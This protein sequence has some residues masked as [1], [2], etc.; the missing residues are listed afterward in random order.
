M[1]LLFITPFFHPH[2]GGTELY[3]EGLLSH[4]VS[5]SPQL[6][7]DGLCYNTDKAPEF[8]K[9]KGLDIY[10]VPCLKIIPGQFVVPKLIPLIKT[11]FKLSKNKY[12]HVLT[13]TRIFD[14]CWWVWLYAK[15]VG[16]KS[17]FIGHGAD[18]V[19]HSSS[20][21]EIVARIVDRTLAPFFVRFYSKV[22]VISSATKYFYQERLG[23][24]NLTLIYGGLDTAQFAGKI[25]SARIIPNI[26]R[27]ID[28][29][30]VLVA[31]V[32]RL[33]WAKGV[34]LMYE[35]FKGVTSTKD[36]SVNLVFAGVGDLQKSLE[37]KVS[38]D[39]LQNRVFFTGLLDPEEVR[40]LLAM[41]DIFVNPSFNEGLP[42][43]VLE[44]AAAGCFV[45]A[46][47]VGSTGEIIQDGNTGMLLES[48]SVDSME[49]AL[50]WY[51]DHPE[52]AVKMANSAQVYV[53]KFF[54]W[55]V[56]SREFYLEVLSD[57]VS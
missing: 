7:V 23:I 26:G 11:L 41:T 27:H 10:R 30:E 2:R 18:F 15:L 47:D 54:D 38:K 56:V 3:A 9:Y 39:G 52:E 5:N 25:T 12:S 1:R 36:S 4:L 14:T 16:A 55:S 24:K 13:Q 19:H 46:T 40:D 45:I 53:R 34:D 20:L 35:A 28:D 33:I 51:L 49:K 42:R 37:D 48:N 50:L 6:E 32:G 43:A 21:V 29:N 57:A 17:I 31:F 8:E 22:V 44:A